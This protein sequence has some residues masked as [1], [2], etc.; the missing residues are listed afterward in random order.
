MSRVEN[1]VLAL[2]A[3]VLAFSLVVFWVPRAW[4]ASNIGI[5]SLARMC[6]ASGIQ[7]QSTL[8][9]YQT[10]FGL[11]GLEGNTYLNDPA[12]PYL[13]EPARTLWRKPPRTMLPLILKL[14]GHYPEFTRKVALALYQEGVPIMAGTDAMGFVLICPG[15]S[16]QKEVL[17]LARA[18]L[19]PYEV[20]RTA[21]VN[22]AAFINKKGEFGMIAPGMRADM[23]L[24]SG[25]PLKDLS[26]VREPLGVMVR[27]CQYIKVATRL[28]R[29]GMDSVIPFTMKVVP[30]QVYSLNFL[31]GYFPTG[32][33]FPTI[34]AA[35]HLEPFS[36]CSARDQIYDRLIIPKWLAAPIRGDE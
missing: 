13:R 5:R 15:T 6:R 24:L 19:K 36:S 28:G 1:A 29:G 31:I 25:N 21:T 35:G 8:V 2:A 3:L 18:G 22:P 11:G 4:R 33:V 7:V 17:L 23:L 14:F 30:L 34:Q 16:L 32:W 10:M 27:R 26:V 20:L 9:V 12:V